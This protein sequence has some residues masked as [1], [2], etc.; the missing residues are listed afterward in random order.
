[1]NQNASASNALPTFTN[2]EIALHI[3]DE[4]WTFEGL[5]RHFFQPA[6]GQT[7]TVNVT[8]L[9]ADAQILARAAL[10]SWE[11]L[12]PLRFVET[13]GTA[14]ITFDD[15]GFG[16]I[17]NFSY[18]EDELLSATVNIA[19][20]WVATYGNGFDTYSMQTYL[21][22]I[23][24]ALG[25]G[26]AGF[27]DGG[28]RYDQDAHYAN[29]SWQ[30]SLMSYFSQVENTEIDASRAFAVTPMVADL[31][32]IQDLY[33]SIDINRGATTYGANSNV[34]GY[35]QTLFEEFFEPGWRIPEFAFT[36]KDDGGRDTF[37]FSNELAN[38]KID[39]NPEGISDV[40]GAI[41]NLIIAVGTTIE[42]AY[43]GAGDDELIGNGAG[44]LLRG[45][46]GNDTLSGGQRSDFLDGG[47]DD[48]VLIGNGG[49]DKL[50]GRSGN[51][52]LFAGAGDDTLSGQGGDD[53]M[54]GGA[55]ADRFEFNLNN[56][57]I[58]DFTDDEDTLALGSRLWD[59]TLTVQQVLDTYVDVSAGTDN[60]IFLQFDGNHSLLIEGISDQ[61]LLLDDIVIF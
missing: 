47:R 16:A 40:G 48:D 4:Y 43:T 37:D 15:E 17:T 31:L 26:H 12:T 7:I 30:A 9:A 14:D 13:S 39:L 23:G 10:A 21:H 54:V 36:V 59:G 41:G 3:T 8:A 49:R 6:D 11:D 5:G 52:T 42:R 58:R 34:G 25:L 22:E 28:G 27:Y 29:D 1:M 33:G 38:Q 50:K 46:D 56:D 51:D 2:A 53:I 24:H 55:G 61:A 35:M 19:A 45:D 20:G 44:N 18:F 32:A 57:I 60:S